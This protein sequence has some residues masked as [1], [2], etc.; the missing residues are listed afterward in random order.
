MSR[1]EHPVRVLAIDPTS[2]GFGFVILEGPSVIVD[3]GVK[4]GRAA[5][6]QREQQLLNRFSDL[7]RQ[8]RP[9]VVILENMSVSESRR[10]GR[11]R[12]L[13]GA[14]ENLA[15]WQNVTVRKIS[16]AQVKKVFNTLDAHSKYEIARVISQH[17]PELVPWIP[18]QRKP[19]TGE[20]YRM[21]AFNA[22]ALALAYLY[23]RSR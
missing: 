7:V 20:D 21:A 12:L 1:A 9:E 5:S 4:S 15:S 8:Y 16:Q 3:W 6:I 23:A 14:M 11:V 2:R 17:V 22:A 10:K 19:W 13:V 18:K